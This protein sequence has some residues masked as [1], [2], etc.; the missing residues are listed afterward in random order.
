[1]NKIVTIFFIIIP[2]ISF[3]QNDTIEVN[4][5]GNSCPEAKNDALINAINQVCGTLINTKTEI[6]NDSLISDKITSLTSGN[7]LSYKEVSPCLNNDG[8]WSV[9]LNVAVSCT[10]LKKFIEGKGKSVAISGE[11][12]KQKVNQELSSKSSEVVIIENLLQQLEPLITEPFDYEINIGQIN[13]LG[14]KYCVLPADISIKSNANFYNVGIKLDKE[15][16]KISINEVDQKYLSVDMT[17]IIYPVTINSKVYNLRNKESVNLIGVFYK[18]ILSKIDDY[19]VVDDCLKELFIQ[20]NNKSNKLKEGIF[21]PEPGFVV[22]TLSGKFNT[23]IDEIGSLN[24]I[25]I[26]AINKLAEYKKGK[27]LSGELTLMKYSETNPL[28]YQSLNKN[29]LVY[30]QE[31]SQSTNEGF[32]DLKYNINITNTGKNENE[33]INLSGSENRY[34]EG[35]QNIINNNTFNP[36]RLCGNFI[37]TTDQISFD[38]SWKTSFE[39]YTYSNKNSEFSNWFNSKSLPYGTYLISKK[40]KTLNNIN[41]SDVTINDFKTRGTSNVINSIIMP[42]WGKRRLTYNSKSGW[43]AFSL[44]FIPLAI[45]IIT[46]HISNENYS[47]YKVAQTKNEIDQYYNQADVKIRR[48]IRW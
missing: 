16:D 26:F 25:N 9:I 12:I 34:Q 48:I 10:E 44:V 22:K 13:I 39:N 27:S 23:T 35:I 4:G 43:G 36:S 14:G 40:D 3:S 41:Y 30:L 11:L 31:V 21:F 42:G 20:E 1:M 17:E 7:I 6:K 33:I 38:F 47:K 24:R 29:I 46:N 2:L 28:E 37:K 19:I 8:K 32:I 45:S 5:K 18:K 15:L